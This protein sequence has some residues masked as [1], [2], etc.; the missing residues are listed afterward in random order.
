MK[1][2]FTIILLTLLI[3][4][5]SAQQFSQKKIEGTW[6]T[7]AV[8]S[9]DKEV[10]G[11]FKQAVFIFTPDGKALIKLNEPLKHKDFSS[12]FKNVSWFFDKKK[13][14]I[15]I[16]NKADQYSIMGIKLQEINNKTQFVLL[17]ANVTLVVE[18]Q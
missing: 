17:E 8:L 2:A 11:I 15:K 3:S 1:K 12:M 6:N 9:N 4:T 16:G 14:I 13:S 5:I 7:T 10:S 18:K